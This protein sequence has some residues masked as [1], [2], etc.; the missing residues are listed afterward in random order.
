MANKGLFE[1]SQKMVAGSQKMEASLIWSFHCIKFII[2]IK[3]VINIKFIEEIQGNRTAYTLSLLFSEFFSLIRK[4]YY[5]KYS[6]RI[7]CI[8][9]IQSILTIRLYFRKHS[10]GVLEIFQGDLPFKLIERF[11][12]L[13]GSFKIFPISIQFLP[14]LTRFS[15]ILG[16][17][18]LEFQ[19]LLFS[20]YQ[21]T[22]NGNS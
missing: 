14:H 9:S 12:S 3:F 4:V 13:P 17:Y 11:Q 16:V 18:Y 5:R 22:Y 20:F 19:L 10:T 6:L 15:K 8:F 21:M 2:I 1:I 7:D